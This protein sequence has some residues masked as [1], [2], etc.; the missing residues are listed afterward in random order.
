[1]NIKDTLKDLGF[2]P[3][4][5]QHFLNS[6]FAVEALVE[7][8]EVEGDVLEIGPG[9]GA[10]TQN[11]KDEADNVYAVE[12][13][14]VLADYLEREFEGH[15]VEVINEDFLEYRVPD[16]DRCVSNLPFEISSD[17]IRKLG[18]HQIQSALIVQK[19]LAEKVVADPGESNYGPTTIMANYYFVPVKL[20]DLSSRYYFPEPQVETSIMKLYPNRERHGIEDEEWFF[21]VAQALFTHSKKKLR[22]AFVDARHILDFEKEEAKEIRDELPHSE[23]RVFQM[24]IRELAEAAEAID[25]KTS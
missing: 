25:A 8:G 11:L 9:T 13:D 15:E 19:E 5:G 17:A 12:K 6:E 21:H 7:A 18:K 10:I 23:K 16:V 22:N 1:M 24:D 4:G 20:R 2:K 3:A 14:T